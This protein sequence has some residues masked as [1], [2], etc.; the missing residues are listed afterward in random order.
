M[1]MIFVLLSLLLVNLDLLSKCEAKPDG[2]EMG[3]LPYLDEDIL[4]IN[5]NDLDEDD[6]DLLPTCDLTSYDPK[7]M[8]WRL[9]TDSQTVFLD[10]DKVVCFYTRKCYE[11]NSTEDDVI[12]QA[13]HVI[14]LELQEGDWLVLQMNL[15]SNATYEETEDIDVILDPVP[16]REAVSCN[17]AV[18]P[19]EA[20]ARWKVRSGEN[21]T[22]KDELLLAGVHVFNVRS[23]LPA[24]GCEVSW[25]LNVTVRTQECARLPEDDICSGKGSCLTDHTLT[26]FTCHCCPGFVG[27]FCEER[28]GC[29]ANPCQHGGFCVDIT[30]GLTG[31]TYQCLC[32]HGFRGQACEEEV[33]LCDRKPCLNN[34]T[35]RGNQTTYWCECPPGYSGRHC[36]ANVNECLSS[37]C[38]HGVCEDGLSGYKCYCLPG[39]GG[40]HCEFEYDECDSSPCIN[41][42]ACED[43][44][45]GYRCHC[46]PGYQGRR[47]QVKV[48]L[49]QPNPCPPPAHCVDRGNNYSCICHP[50]YNGP[51]CTQ[52][53]DPCF[54]NPCQ[55]GGSCWPSLDSFFCSCRPGYTGDTCEELRYPGMPMAHTLEDTSVYRSATIGPASASLDHL[56]NLYIA[57][58][59]LAGACLI[60]LAV[61]TICHCRVH[62]TYRRFTRKLTRNSST[63]LKQ[64]QLEDPDKYSLRWCG[65]ASEVCG[66][67][68]RGGKLDGLN[69]DLLDTVRTPLI[70]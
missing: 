58:A 60:V 32:P 8:K 35:C 45:A 44:V 54:P 52:Q 59:T 69:R 49:C 5:R 31:S 7:M 9:Q 57:A 16:E 67:E 66:T 48:D 30:E 50:G 20:M 33:N 1:A 47:C 63:D 53:Y 55:N 27:R 37:P 4:G 46:G 29:Y 10:F 13:N 2:S 42:G 26:T 22:L 70:H 61:V 19:I 23:R 6:D 62:K 64:N 43:L 14:Q 40:D 36:D 12:I 25:T 51:G 21:I 65:S 28:D 39:Y 11:K 24:T 3:L 15:S 17:L 68:G 34:G 41:G 56:H 38:V 18:L